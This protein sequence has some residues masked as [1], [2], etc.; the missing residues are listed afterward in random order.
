MAAYNVF[1]YRPRRKCP[2]AH[3]HGDFRFLGQLFHREDDADVDDVVEVAI[4]AES[5]KPRISWIAGGGPT[6]DAR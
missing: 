2:A 1:V 6:H 5:W 4:D 3:M